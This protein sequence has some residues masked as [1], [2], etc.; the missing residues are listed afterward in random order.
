MSLLS[1]MINILHKYNV[2]LNTNVSGTFLFTTRPWFQ[3]TS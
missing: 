1:L 3:L 2:L